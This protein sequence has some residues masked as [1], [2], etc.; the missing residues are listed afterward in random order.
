MKNEY[1]LILIINLGIFLLPSCNKPAPEVFVRYLN[2]YTY[3]AL[4]DNPYTNQT[5]YTYENNDKLVIKD[6]RRI[7]EG[8]KE[9]D[10]KLFK[11]TEQYNDKYQ[12]RAK[13]LICSTPI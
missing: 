12:L 10:V 2:K 8:D 5:T 3:Q 11:T 4:G 7:F 9:V 1:K 6:I 13:Y